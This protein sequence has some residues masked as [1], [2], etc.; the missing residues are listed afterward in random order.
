MERD[1]AHRHLTRFVILAMLF[2]Y[3]FYGKATAME[4]SAVTINV[5][6]NR[7]AVLDPFSNGEFLFEIANGTERDI[8]IRSLNDILVSLTA[9]S[10]LF[11]RRSMSLPMTSALLLEQMHEKRNMVPSE[12]V[13]IPAHGKTPFTFYTYNT[14]P[15]IG[16]PTVNLTVIAK[17]PDGSQISSNM[18]TIK[19]KKYSVLHSHRLL[20]IQ[21][22]NVFIEL[23]LVESDGGKIVAVYYSSYPVFDKIPEYGRDGVYPNYESIY[24]V[25]SCLKEVKNAIP[26]STCELFPYEAQVALVSDKRL[27]IAGL[28]SAGYD[29]IR[30]FEKVLSVKI[31]AGVTVEKLMRYFQKDKPAYLLLVSENG[32]KRLDILQKGLA[33]W[34]TRTVKS[35][36][37]INT[38]D[39]EKINPVELH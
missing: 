2:F 21:S 30:E 29:I 37:D 9:D 35:A 3:P 4:K 14:L 38:V 22:T 6:L 34:G 5:L 12:P 1:P 7:D 31:P 17:L 19:V 18:T 16:A 33:G 13:V 24:A 10:E 25:L 11:Y 27:E 36:I 23:K 15:F 39:F 26:V 28:E 32:K 8:Q 20:V